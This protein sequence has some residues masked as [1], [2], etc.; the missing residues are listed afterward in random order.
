MEQVVL[1]FGIVAIVVVD[2]DSRF[3]SKFVAMYKILKLTFWP[4]SCGN[5]KG[6]LVEHYHHFL[7]KDR[8]FMA[9]TEGLMKCSTKMFVHHST[10]GTV[11]QSMI[12][13]YRGV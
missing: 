2:A 3:L 11:H 10:L 12:P 8:L 9:K 5:H 13:I 1:N 7:N 6:N 4:L